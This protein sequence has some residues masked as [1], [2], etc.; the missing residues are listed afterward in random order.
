MVAGHNWLLTAAASLLEE[1]SKQQGR[2]LDALYR[3]LRAT[4]EI[5]PLPNR[6][7]KL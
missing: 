4:V 2:M 5:N 7:F 6:K 1:N 3:V